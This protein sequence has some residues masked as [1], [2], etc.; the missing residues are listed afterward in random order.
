MSRHLCAG[1]QSR[2]RFIKPFRLGAMAALL[3]IPLLGFMSF[4]PGAGAPLSSAGALGPPSGVPPVTT[5]TMDCAVP[6]IG[7]LPLQVSIF[8]TAPGSVQAGRSVS[9]HAVRSTVAIPASLV[10]LALEFGITTL[11]GTISTVDFD[12]TNATPAVLNS[13]SAPASF[14]P[15]TL[16]E[17]QPATFQ[18]PS[19]PQTVG[20]WTAGSSGNTITYTP[21]EVDLTVLLSFS[22]TPVSPAP[23]AT[24]TIR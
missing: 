5:Y 9:L 18:V 17:G 13:L 3:S 1:A 4:A 16:V 23:L 21:G 11:S 10:D 8:A 22:C 24:T 2:A 20:P 14:G 15:I 19:T 7:T 12:A 6:I